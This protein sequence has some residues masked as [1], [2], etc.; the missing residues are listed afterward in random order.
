MTGSHE[1][2]GSGKNRGFVETS[3]GLV[4]SFDEG[5]DLLL[6]WAGDECGDPYRVSATS[7][8]RD[9]PVEFIDLKTVSDFEPWSEYLG[10]ILDY[11]QVHTYL[12]EDGRK[13]PWGIELCLG[14]RFLLV[15]AV[16]HKG[17]PSASGCADEVVVVHDPQLIGAL[18]DSFTHRQA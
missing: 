17:F 7:A 14:G 5:G 4:L 11:F 12:S 6:T 3:W 18:R 9:S 8:N 13:I 16:A 1:E 2:Y 15:A 10:A